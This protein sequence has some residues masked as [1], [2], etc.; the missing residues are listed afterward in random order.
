MEGSVQGPG[1]A[2]CLRRALRINFAR[3]KLLQKQPGCTV[4]SLCLGHEPKTQTLAPGRP[5]RVLN[6]ASPAAAVL[7]RSLAVIL[8]SSKRE[9]GVGWFFL[10]ES[11]AISVK[12]WGWVYPC[13]AI[14]ACLRVPAGPSCAANSASGLPPASRST[15]PEK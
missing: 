14:S 3:G 15:Q 8:G 11:K 13:T 10:Q 12:S 5:R 9:L 6:S 2:S 7:V 1:K 4:A